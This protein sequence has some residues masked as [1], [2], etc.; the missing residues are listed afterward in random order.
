MK[1]T[2]D[3]RKLLLTPMMTAAKSM[4]EA[5]RWLKSNKS[6]DQGRIVPLES[7]ENLADI[8]Q[9][10]YEEPMAYVAQMEIVN[11]RLVSRGAI[12]HGRASF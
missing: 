5:C 7:V 6:G 9:S 11:I 2:E 1:P 10:Y 12:L 4:Y 8:Y 3:E